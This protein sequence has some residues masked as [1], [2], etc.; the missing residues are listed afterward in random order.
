M[1]R[2]PKDYPVGRPQEKGVDVALAV[3]FVCLAFQSAYDVGVIVSHDTDLIPPLEAVR[4]LR[5]A[6]VEVAGW[7]GRNRLQFPETKFPWHH[8]L[9]E[10]D[11]AAVRDDTDYLQGR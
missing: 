3:D 9:Y 7:R 1:L 6:H 11:F 2:Y 5:L 4:E 10:A 8:D